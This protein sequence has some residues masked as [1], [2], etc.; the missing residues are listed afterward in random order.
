MTKEDLDMLLRESDGKELMD[1]GREVS[2]ALHDEHIPLPD[3]EQELNNVM[4]VRHHHS[5]WHIAAVIAASVILFGG[6]AYAF[7]GMNFS[8]RQSCETVESTETP[9]YDN[10]G[11]SAG[12][13]KDD[14]MDDFVFEE[15][16]MENIMNVLARHY[17][18]RVEFRNPRAKAVRMH[19]QIDRNMSLDS[20]VTFLNTFT[21]NIHITLEAD[22][23]YI[24]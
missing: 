1:M 18:V 24:E 8:G 21:T 14:D 2:E 7:I 15:E 20:A 23:I 3:I 11:N 6:L 9:V 22:T 12:E 17:G 13:T 19:M 4:P 10:V 5:V 16:S